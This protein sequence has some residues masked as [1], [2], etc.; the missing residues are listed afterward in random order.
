M[1]E[2]ENIIRQDNDWI[3]ITFFIMFIILAFQKILFENRLSHTSI[4]FLKK[5]R[6]VGYFNKDKNIFF[7]FYQVLSFVVQILSISLL[8]YFLRSF[9]IF[10]NTYNALYFYLIIVAGVSSYFIIRAIIGSFFAIIFNLETIHKKISYE[11]I[12]YTNNLILWTLPLLVITNYAKNNFDLFLKITLVVFILLVLLRYLL[13]IENNKK[14]IFNNLFYF[15]L[16]LCVLEIA[17]LVII[18]KLTI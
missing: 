10:K 7:N 1:I 5:G 16:Y 12:S 3:T 13:I 18:I 17:P 15:I 9:F 8:L 11:K 6:V 4:F 14:L 2:A